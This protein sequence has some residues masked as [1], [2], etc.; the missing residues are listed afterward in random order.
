MFEVDL[1]SISLAVL[2][3]LGWLI[4]VFLP[5]AWVT[6]GLPFGELKFWARVMIGMTL[7]PLAVCIQFYAIR[8]LGASFEST[9]LFLI[10]INLPVIFLIWRRR[11][12]PS[13]PDYKLLFAGSFVLLVAVSCL[14]PQ[15]LNGQTRMFTAHA[16]M[17]GDLIYMLRNG[18]LWLEDPEL[19]GIRLAYPWSGHV[20]QAVLSYLINSAPVT[21]YIWTNVIWLV[22]FYGFS[23]YIT[24][25]LG[26]NNFSKVSSFIWLC[27]GL[28]FVGY[29]LQQTLPLTLTKKLWIGGDYRYTP[30]ILKL[31]FFEQIIFG[32]AMFG[33]LVYLLIKIPNRDLTAKYSILIGLL[34]CGTVLVYPI[35]FVPA[36]ITAAVKLLLILAE[37]K[38]LPDK[39]H[40]RKTINL[41]LILLSVIIFAF[42]YLKFLTA[43]RVTESIKLPSTSLSF[44]KYFILKTQGSFVALSLLLTGF[45]LTLKKLW[46]DNRDAEIILASGAVGSLLLNLFL[47]I[48]FW[49]NEYKFL[50]TAAICLAPFPALASERLIKHYKLNTVAVFA[51]TLLILVAPFIHKLYKDFPWQKIK[52]P[53][54]D[55]TNFE[56]TLASTE[57][58]STLCRTIRQKTLVDTILVIDQ[59]ELHF[60]TLTGRRLYAPPEQEEARAGVNISSYDLLTKVRGYDR[61]VFDGRKTVVKTLYASPESDARFRSL[62]QILELRRP[63][64]VILEMPRHRGLNEWFAK[65]N[66]SRLYEDKNRVLWFIEKPR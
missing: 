5:G 40:L 11:V 34:L 53:A 17:H 10:F 22:C 55:D 2:R 63:V 49:G 31:Y 48:P 6:F 4:L 35:I 12:K 20:F 64:A 56:L 7:A 13:R 46:S 37:K 60:P 15:L 8:L 36:F 61:T 57:E 9:S 52:P 51:L 62:E 54:T 19:A 28:N 27:L 16:W 65:N 50:F 47:E 3:V 14:A 25:E 24:E 32:L 44:V 1:S 29:V 33:A 18:D 39:A 42:L 21:S 43:E 66:F 59:T 26:G 30:W 23:Y 41:G 45:F 38:K 58:M